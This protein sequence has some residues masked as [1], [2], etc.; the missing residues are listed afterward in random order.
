MRVNALMAG[1]APRPGHDRRSNCSSLDTILLP[2]PDLPVVPIGRK[3]ALLSRRANQKQN[4]AHPV[5]K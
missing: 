4:L 2:A 5:P 1:A 3:F